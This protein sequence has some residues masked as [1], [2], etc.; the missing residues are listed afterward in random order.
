M[1]SF[2]SVNH[3]H[4]SLTRDMITKPQQ[5]NI[6]TVWAVTTNLYFFFFS[7]KN[8]ELRLKASTDGI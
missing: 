8:K 1:F 5:L 6:H 2:V 3:I 7:I 4:L